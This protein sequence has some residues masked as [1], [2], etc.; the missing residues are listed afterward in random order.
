VIFRN[1]PN[2]YLQFRFSSFFPCSYLNN[3]PW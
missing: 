3:R 1:F 2:N